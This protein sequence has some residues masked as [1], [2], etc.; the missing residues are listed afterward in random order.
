MKLYIKKR[1]MVRIISF[2]AA[3]VLIFAGTVAY[4]QVRFV[5]L[6]RQLAHRYQS[7]MENLSSEMENI[8]V[9]RQKHFIQAPPPP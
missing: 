1:H 8:S 7:A 4:N 9:T 5:S 2:A 3:F 6:K